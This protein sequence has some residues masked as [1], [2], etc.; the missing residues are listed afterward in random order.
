[1]Y[2]NQ[3]EIDNIND[4]SDVVFDI[5]DSSGGYLA[6]ERYCNLEQRIRIKWWAK[7]MKEYNQSYWKLLLMMVYYNIG[8]PI[9]VSFE[10]VMKSKK[11]DDFSTVLSYEGFDKDIIEKLFEEDVVINTYEYVR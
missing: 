6:I 4:R 5:F 3:E 8:N 10:G 2:L 1:M 9:D 11:S 7:N